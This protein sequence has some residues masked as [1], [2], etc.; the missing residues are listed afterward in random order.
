MTIDEIH[1]TLERAAMAAYGFLV[2]APTEQVVILRRLVS[3]QFMTVDRG[4]YFANRST[5]KHQATCVV[6]MGN[7]A[8][9]Q[10]LAQAVPPSLFNAPPSTKAPATP[11]EQKGKPS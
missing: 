2:I 4:T 9:L 3:L 5:L 10:Q 8:D 1:E 6:F 7:M 11:P